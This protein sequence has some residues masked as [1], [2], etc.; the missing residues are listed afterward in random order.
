MNTSFNYIISPEISKFKKFSP[1]LKIGVLASGKGTN[2][3]ELIN[4]SQKSILDVD[5]KVLITNKD[6]AYCI[7]RADIA[8]IP[9]E[10]IRD[11]DFSQNKLFELEIINVLINYDVELV[12]MAGW[13]KIVSPLF[14]NKFKNK[15]I[16]IHPSLLPAYK[17][18]SAIRDSLLNGSKITGCSVH[19][20]EEKVDS[21]SLIM[22]AALPVLNDDNI[23]TLSKKIQILEHKIL[24]HSI[25]HAGYLIRSDLRKV[26]R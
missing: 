23:E 17:G 11:K 6:D 25:S 2:F 22:Q 13:M 20:V 18:S 24:P 12:V 19:F 7:K 1:K 16:N 3:Q 21:G 9:R 8:E 10:I 26:I 15:I 14:I 4:L 5:I